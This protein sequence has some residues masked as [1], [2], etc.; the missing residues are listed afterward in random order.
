MRTWLSKHNGAP[1][2]RENARSAMRRGTCELERTVRVRQVMI[3]TPSRNIATG[4]PSVDRKL[5]TPEFA[6]SAR[7]GQAVL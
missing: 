5:T 3:A 4:V 6:R 2:V 7:S 1:L